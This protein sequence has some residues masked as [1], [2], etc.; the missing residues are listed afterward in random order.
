MSHIRTHIT[1]DSAAFWLEAGGKLASAD[2][3]R[4]KPYL[5]RRR[6]PVASRGFSFN[7]GK[8]SHDPK[9]PPNHRC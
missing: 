5:L 8:P 3:S 7:T 6:N 9:I 4:E 2:L 1:D